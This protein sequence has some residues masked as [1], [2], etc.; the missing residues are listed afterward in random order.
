MM[1]TVA[2]FFILVLSA[3]I[4]ILLGRELFKHR[5]PFSP[6]G[7]VGL[8]WL[9]YFIGPALDFA[10]MLPSK[11]SRLLLGNGLWYIVPGLVL[12]LIGVIA[13]IGG[14]RLGTIKLRVADTEMTYRVDYRRLRII[15]YACGAIG[16]VGLILFFKSTGGI[17]TSLPELST[18]RDLPTVYIRWL[19]EFLFL[20]SL[21]GWARYCHHTDSM[22]RLRTAVPLLWLAIALAPPFLGSNRGMLLLMVIGHIVLVHYLH[23]RVRIGQLLPLAPVGVSVV[24][25]MLWLRQLS[26]A[27]SSVRIDSIAFITDSLRSTFGADYGSLT[28]ISHLVHMVPGDL[29]YSYGIT[30]FKW[31]V[32]PIPRSLWPG[33][34]T[35]LGQVLGTEVYGRPNGTPPTLLGELYLNYDLLGVLIGMVIVGVCF[36]MLYLNLI[37]KANRQPVSVVIYLLFIIAGFGVADMTKMMTSLL[38]WLIP[39]GAGFLFAISSNHLDRAGCSGVFRRKRQSSVQP[40]DSD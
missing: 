6:M 39:L 17:P 11:R 29:G 33:K 2:V 31:V 27:G 10:T 25:L 37:V 36:R 14:W 22:V 24:G 3:S 28:M 9:M 35:N 18:K 13:L 40:N 21:L 19:T 26:R 16:L 8:F 7:F 34:P 12:S 32:F 20:A 23:R 15:Q 1:D 38:R 5:D 4:I 30:L